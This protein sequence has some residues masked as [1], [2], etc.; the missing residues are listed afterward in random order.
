[1][2]VSLFKLLRKPDALYSPEL[3]AQ[4]PEKLLHLLLPHLH[5]SRLFDP[6]DDSGRSTHGSFLFV[7]ELSGTKALSAADISLLQKLPVA[8][9]DC[10]GLLFVMRSPLL[11]DVP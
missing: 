9:K 5:C 2:F 10:L 11:Y 8:M 3:L 1:M 4:V 7:I 6:G